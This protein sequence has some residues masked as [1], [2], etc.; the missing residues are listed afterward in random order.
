MIILTAVC[1]W[2]I[3]TFC[4]PFHVDRNSKDWWKCPA[5]HILRCCQRFKI[6]YHKYMAVVGNVSWTTEAKGMELFSV[7]MGNVPSPR[8]RQANWSLDRKISGIAS[9]SEDNISAIVLFN[10]SFESGVYCLL[11]NHV[12]KIVFRNWF[13]RDKFS[14]ATSLTL[15]ILDGIRCS[16]R[17]IVVRKHFGVNQNKITLT[18]L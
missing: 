8:W 12:I 5:L 16:L 18:G 13:Y 11:A 7:K 10:L 14:G 17:G 15:W 2:C 1:L 3:M 9:G 6:M 4:L